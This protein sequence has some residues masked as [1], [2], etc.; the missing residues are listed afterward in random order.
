VAEMTQKTTCEAL[1]IEKQCRFST[2]S[3]IGSETVAIREDVYKPLRC[4]AIELIR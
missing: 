3:A 2:Q 1:K 4:K